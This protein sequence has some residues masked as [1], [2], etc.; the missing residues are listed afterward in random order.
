MSIVDG[1]GVEGYS[2]HFPFS[3]FQGWTTF[4]LSDLGLAEGK[5]VPPAD[6]RHGAV[7]EEDV[8]VAE[9]LLIR[10]GESAAGGENRTSF[11]DS[12]PFAPT[13]PSPELFTEGAEEE[14]GWG[15]AGRRATGV[16]FGTRHGGGSEGIRAVWRGSAISNDWD[17]QS[18]PF[19]LPFFL[20]LGMV[21]P[22]IA[23][24]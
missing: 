2:P 8:P 18:L 10:I 11:E 16:V 22:H 7:L 14:P 21:C 13:L 1:V 19:F 23:A 3:L 6:V 20:K 15:S 5:P 24:V 12:V 4:P 9:S 17:C